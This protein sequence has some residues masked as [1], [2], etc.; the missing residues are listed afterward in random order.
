MCLEKKKKKRERQ[1]QCSE[2]L[3]ECEFWSRQ[4]IKH[5]KHQVQTPD[6]IYKS[7]FVNPA[8]TPW[9]QIS[10]EEFALTP[11]SWN[12]DVSGKHK[13]HCMA[14]KICLFWSTQPC[15]NVMKHSELELLGFKECDTFYYTN[16]YKPETEL[17]RNLCLR[18]STADCV[19]L[20]NAFS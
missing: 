16:L 11:C 14:N 5:A 6:L 20:P 12:E 13:L 19:S 1:M 3:W 9:I 10:L 4:N 15:S 18:G 17:Q 2:Q 7:S 8:W